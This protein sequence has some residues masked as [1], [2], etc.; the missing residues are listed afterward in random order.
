MAFAINF[1]FDI[2]RRIVC[3]CCVSWLCLPLLVLVR[4][5]SAGEVDFTRDIRPL[6]SDRCLL[7][8]GPDSTQR[9]SELRLD[10]QASAYA[11]AIK[12]GRPGE[13]EL[14]RRITSDDADEVMPP[15]DS[16]LQLSVAEKEL[17]KAWVEQGAEYAKHW[18]F[19]A[20]TKPA[21][22]PVR[23]ASWPRND[24]D[25]F[26]LSRLEQEKLTPSPDADAETILRRVSLDLTG[27]PPSVEE[28]D[29]YLVEQAN[30]RSLAG[31]PSVW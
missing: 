20:P 27:L 19:V 25:R 26:V 22:P 17:L 14:I 5:T 23:Q 6:L 7:C 24:L 12:P 15:P 10:E 30:G 9:A 1:R 3:A 16:N 18:A 28:I 11:L 4:Q 21:L 31:Q 8:H 2:H 29:N 13:S